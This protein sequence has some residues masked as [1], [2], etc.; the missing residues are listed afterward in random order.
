MSHECGEAVRHPA[1]RL[2]R[3]PQRHTVSAGDACLWLC[4]A[5]RPCP[6][7]R[8]PNIRIHCENCAILH[9]DHSFSRCWGKRSQKHQWVVFRTSIL[10]SIFFQLTALRSG[11]LTLTVPEAAPIAHSEA[12]YASQSLK[13]SHHSPLFPMSGVR[14]L[15]MAIP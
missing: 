2:G 15:R 7:E 5:A 9:G 4:S 11:S 14:T 6:G 13:I 12:T 8:G 1:K 3:A 10:T